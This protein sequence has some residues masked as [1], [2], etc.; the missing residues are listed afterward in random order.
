MVLMPSK[1]AEM[2]GLLAHR[3]YTTLF[4][5]FVPDALDLNK[6]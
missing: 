4:P 3:T 5:L 2:K 1:G 6:K